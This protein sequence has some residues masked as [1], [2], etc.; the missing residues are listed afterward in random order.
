MMREA[1]GQFGTLHRLR[2]KPGIQHQK[3]SFAGRG[4]LPDVA[5][6][7]HRTRLVIDGSGP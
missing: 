5:R 7:S 4:V 1:I 3:T 2:S 6:S